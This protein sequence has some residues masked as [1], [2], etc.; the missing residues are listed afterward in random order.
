MCVFIMDI[1][2]L[3]IDVYSNELVYLV[4]Q[5][6]DV[7]IA[8][9]KATFI[10]F[11]LIVSFRRYEFATPRIMTTISSFLQE[12]RT[13]F[14]YVEIRIIPPEH[15]NAKN[16][17]TR[18]NFFEIN[19]HCEESPVYPFTRHDGKGRFL[20]LMHFDNDTT[21]EV[22]NSLIR[23]INARISGGVDFKLAITYPL[24]ELTDNTCCHSEYAYGGHIC[25]Q[26]YFDCVEVAIVDR[27]IGIVESLRAD[28]KYRSGTDSEILLMSVAESVSS[29]LNDPTRDHQGFGLYALNEIVKQG[30]GT[31][32]IYANGACLKTENGCTSAQLMSN[33]SGTLIYF[34]LPI[35]YNV[36]QWAQ[37]MN[38][39][40]VERGYHVPDHLLDVEEEN[41][42]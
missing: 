8:I 36:M 39:L 21:D 4:E 33:W 13:T 25:V 22:N 41:I 17:M 32:E 3:F 19:P 11:E 5:I 27:G 42:F 23:I 20:E 7:E 9:K 6:D 35:N 18:F 34:R 38:R 1:E 2:Q 12:V 37:I 40:F 28:D 26:P 30:N 10:D 14:P 15:E 29:K 24:V 16:Y 31:L